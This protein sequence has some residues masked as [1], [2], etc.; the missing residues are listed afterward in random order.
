MGQTERDGFTLIE[1]LVTISIVGILVAILMPAVQSV[2]EASRRTSCA[3]NQRQFA[4]ALHSFESGFGFV[5]PTLGLRRKKDFLLHWQAALTP[6]LEQESLFEQINTKIA[7]SVHV[8]HM[9]ER[10][11]RLPTFECPSDPEFGMLIEADT[12]RFAFTSYC[13]VGGVQLSENDGFFLSSLSETSARR[14]GQGVLFADIRDG[15]SNTLM[16]GERPPNDAGYGY[17]SWLG[18]QNVAAAAIGV[19]ETRESLADNILLTGCEETDFQYGEGTRGTDCGWTHHWS[20]HPGGSN[21][22]MADGS[23]HFVQ[24]GIERETLYALATRASGDIPGKY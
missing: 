4:L 1:L 15:L 19:G 24:Y 2:R 17:G 10:T 6:Y 3:N 9:E 8:F 23:V 16:I 21:F 12:G 22:A 7:K 5:P 11:I 18:S 13:G 14:V 20:Y